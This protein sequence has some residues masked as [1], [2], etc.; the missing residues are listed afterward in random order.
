M[1]GEGESNEGGS[2]GGE[3]STETTTTETTTTSSEG[4]TGAGQQTDTPKTFTKAE[5]EA[6]IRDRIGTT[7]KAD[8]D[9]VKEAIGDRKLGDVAKILADLDE[10]EEAKKDEH[11]KAMEAAATAKAE[12]DTAKAEAQTEALKAKL[13]IALTTPTKGEDDKPLPTVTHEYLDT[14]MVLALPLARAS[15]D[16][17]P[18]AA[19]VAAVRVSAAPMFGSPSDATTDG[20]NG[21]GKKPAPTPGRTHGEDGS[22]QSTDKERNIADFK[23]A[24]GKS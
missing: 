10:A 8:A 21:T 18:V 13:M 7:K 4:T 1:A 14:V 9:K 3:G 20:T 12:A 5:V 19:A 15:E 2:T 24:M 16:D 17:D 23:T 22:G 6:M 11:T